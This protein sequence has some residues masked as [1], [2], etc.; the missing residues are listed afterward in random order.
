MNPPTIWNQADTNHQFLLGKSYNGV[1]IMYPSS[2]NILIK[3][4][5][6]LRLGLETMTI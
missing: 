1:F 6:G 2:M 4:H 3:C 5:K